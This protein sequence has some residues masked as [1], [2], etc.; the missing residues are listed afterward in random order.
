MINGSIFSSFSIPVNQLKGD[1]ALSYL[2]LKFGLI[3]TKHRP[4]KMIITELIVGISRYKTKVERRIATRI[5]SGQGYMSVRWKSVRSIIIRIS[6]VIGDI[7]GRTVS[8][9]EGI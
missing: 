2:L 6:V 5:A 1:L 7:V 8:H 3:N 9:C 4:R